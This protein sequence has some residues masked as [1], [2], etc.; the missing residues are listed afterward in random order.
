MS[1]H[2]FDTAGGLIKELLSFRARET[3]RALVRG[4][5]CIA[6]F[7][8]SVAAQ[9]NSRTLDEKNDIDLIEL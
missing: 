8:I 3:K 4:L 5:V 6:N 7:R 1:T 2:V 9:M